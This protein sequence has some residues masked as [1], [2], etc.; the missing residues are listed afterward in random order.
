MNRHGRAPERDARRYARAAVRPA[1]TTPTVSMAS[2]VRGRMTLNRSAGVVA[3]SA[4]QAT[5]SPS[6]AAVTAC[7]TRARMVITATPTGR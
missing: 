1:T 7:G 2:L 5:A 3:I 6:T 4:V